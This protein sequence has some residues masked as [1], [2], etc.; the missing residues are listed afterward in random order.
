MN[1]GAQPSDSVT[2]LLKSVGAID[3]YARLKAGEPVET[4]QAEA[5]A[6]YLKFNGQTAK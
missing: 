3:R 6:A 5:Q 4:L 2:Q 1:K